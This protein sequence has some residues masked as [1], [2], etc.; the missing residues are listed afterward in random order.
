VI[1]WL[2]LTNDVDAERQTVEVGVYRLKSGGS[3]GF[4]LTFFGI[5]A[6]FV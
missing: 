6:V 5:V 3:N 2:T 4:C 1:L